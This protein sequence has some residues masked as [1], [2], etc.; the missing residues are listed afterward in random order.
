[1][2][3]GSL[4]AQGAGTVTATV[5]VTSGGL[6]SQDLNQWLSALSS[7]TKAIITDAEVNSTAYPVQRM[8]G[9]QLV[10]PPRVLSQVPLDLTLLP[11]WPSGVDELN[12]LLHSPSVGKPSSMLTAI[13]GEEGVRFADGCGGALRVSPDGLTVSTVSIS[14]SCRV[15]AQV[16]NFSFIASNEFVIA[17]RRS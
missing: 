6:S 14:P 13:A 10:A 12:P 2:T 3:P 9:I 16:G 1:M 11:V 8:T 5:P 15:N 7:R 17:A 4:A